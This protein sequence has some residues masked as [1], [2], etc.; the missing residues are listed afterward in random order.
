MKI[1]FDG[2]YIINQND[3]SHLQLNMFYGVRV[4]M[5]VHKTLGCCRAHYVLFE[6]VSHLKCI[7]LNAIARAREKNTKFDFE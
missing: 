4:I 1:N 2:V 3:P 7:A 5:H 6:I